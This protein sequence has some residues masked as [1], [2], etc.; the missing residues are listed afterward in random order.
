MA[1]SSHT[2]TSHS[3]PRYTKGIGKVVTDFVGDDGTG[4][5][6]ALTITFP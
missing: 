3:I 4:A 2:L 6:P 1:N 5:I